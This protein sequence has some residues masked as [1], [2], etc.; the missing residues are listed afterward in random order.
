MR[1]VGTSP[2]PEVHYNN[3]NTQKKFNAKKFKRI[4]RE[5]GTTKTSIIIRKTRILIKAKA[6]PKKNFRHDNC[7]V[8]QRCGCNN[9]ITKKCHT[10]KRLVELY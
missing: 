9:H 2:L 6:L 10:A 8:C 7:Q 4:S 3:Q 5:N 1:L